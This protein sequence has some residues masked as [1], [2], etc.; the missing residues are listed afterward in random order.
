ME[1]IKIKY[2]FGCCL[3]L[4]YIVFF[5]LSCYNKN[6]Q[7]LGNKGAFSVKFFPHCI[8]WFRSKRWIYWAGAAILAL[9]L[10]I[11]FIVCFSFCHRGPS[12]TPER[13]YV[14]EIGGIP[15]YT[16]FIPEDSGGRPGIQRTVRYVV[17]HETGNP[18]P[19]ADAQA[20]SSYLMEGGDGSTS[21]HYT[22][23]DKQIYH[24]VP[25]QEVAWHAGDKTREG[26]GNLNGI[27]VELC[28]NE[29]GD[30]EKTFENGA[31]LTAYLLRS[32]GL[33]IDDVKQH[34]DFNGKNCPQTIRE[35]DRWQEFL[36]AVEKN[37][38]QL[39]P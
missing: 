29:D 20:H 16:K 38:N 15:L 12:V 21:W 4:A 24:H 18:S 6:N 9:I 1:F 7:L 26:G 22:V 35:E 13:P 27:G 19:G 23:D 14:D 28:V 11:I 10:L 2:C 36:D 39:E 8:I 37:L 34:H 33:S 3:S 25:D 31:K 30:F 32:Y 17:I 5:N